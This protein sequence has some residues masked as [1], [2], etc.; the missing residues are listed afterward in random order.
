MKGIHNQMLERQR[1]VDMDMI[2][3]PSFTDAMNDLNINLLKDSVLSFPI[4]TLSLFSMN[5]HLKC[6]F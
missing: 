5:T 4:V 6:Q 2:S 3:K 1:I